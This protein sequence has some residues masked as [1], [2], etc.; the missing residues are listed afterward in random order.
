[1]AFATATVAVTT[2]DLSQPD[3]KCESGRCAAFLNK[4]VLENLQAL[5]K[6]LKTN[7]ENHEIFEEPSW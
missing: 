5:G 4:C 3:D 7:V 1:L 2:L 6:K